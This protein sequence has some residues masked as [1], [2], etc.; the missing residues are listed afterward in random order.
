MGN[1]RR[2]GSNHMKKYY[3]ANLCLASSVL[4]GLLLLCCRAEAQP[5]PLHG[6]WWTEDQEAIV[7]FYP[8]ETKLCGRFHWLKDNDPAKPS[9][10]DNNPDPKQQQRILCGLTFIGGFKEV[11]PGRFEHGWIYSPRHGRNF[12]AT[13]TLLDENH[14]ELR[15]YVLTSLL[16][17]SQRWQRATADSPACTQAGPHSSP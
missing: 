15:G 6:L 11:K 2:E 5:G 7:E 10:D 3:M 12:D 1:L 4:C 13:I 14:L 8:C 17:S 9:R 16:G